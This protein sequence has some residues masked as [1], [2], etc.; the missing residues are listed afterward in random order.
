MQERSKQTSHNPSKMSENAANDRQVS[1]MYVRT[2]SWETAKRAREKISG[3][4]W[5]TWNKNNNNE[6]KK[7]PNNGLDARKSSSSSSL[8][9]S[10]AGIG[11]AAVV[12]VAGSSSYAVNRCMKWSTMPEQ[13]RMT[14]KQNKKLSH[15]IYIH[16]P[17]I[18]LSHLH[19][20]CTP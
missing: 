7:A 11:T 16:L 3:K 12:M 9:L 14:E 4:W 5:E 17:Q 10:A 2:P 1:C 15:S 19:N 6:G 18:H 8:L 13:L 20:H